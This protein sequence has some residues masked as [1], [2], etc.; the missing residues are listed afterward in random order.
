V[1]DRL[2]LPTQPV[3]RGDRVLLREARESDIDDR[4]RHPIDP[5]EEDGYGS[6]WRREWDGRRYHTRE[7]L[8]A[9]RAQPPQPGTYEWAIEHAGQ[10]IGGARL[11]V[12]TDQHG[13]TYSV[14][15]FVAGLRGHGLGREITRLV[16]AWAFTALGAHR[17]QLEVLAGNDAAIRCYLACGF[18]QEGIRREAMLYPDGWRDLIFMSVLSA[19]YPAPH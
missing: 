17:V 12:D 14:G 10:F 18:R 13:A 6:S 9:A 5:V 8:I 11:E 3:L 7:H 15:L 19:E 4:L 2:G 1:L 16:L